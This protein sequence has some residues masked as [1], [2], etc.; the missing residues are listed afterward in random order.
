MAISILVTKILD[1]TEVVAGGK[2]EDE[3]GTSTFSPTTLSL[4]IPSTLV[5]FTQCL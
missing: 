5:S 3:S 4:G 2:D 1:E